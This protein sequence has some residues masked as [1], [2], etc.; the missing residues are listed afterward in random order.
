[1]KNIPLKGFISTLTIL[2]LALPI[3]SFTNISKTQPYTVK[4]IVID[5]GHG[6]KFP[7]AS[8]NYSRE[9][10]V[11]LKIALRLGKAIEENFKDVKV[12]YTR[13]TDTELASIKA[14]DLRERINIANR[15]NADLL[16]SIHCNSMGYVRYKTG[17]KDSRGRPIY[18]L[19]RETATKGVET[20]V[21]GSERLDEQQDA[22]GEFGVL[23]EEYKEDAK[24]DSNDPEVAIALSLVA[25]E[26]RKRSIQLASLIQDEYVAVGRVNR[27]YKE[28]SLAVLRTAIMPCVLTEVGFISNPEEEDYMNSESG[29]N[30]I[31]SCLLKAIQSYKKHVEFE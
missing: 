16:I 9:Q 10:D 14:V 29:Q 28:Q 19:R 26:L 7:G 17:K 18:K 27:G 23:K 2:L 13:T 24:F 12:I 21:A 6:G 30:E 25:N 1:M 8:G 15:A 11:T 3:V 22:L 20:F 31:V 5:P 4:T